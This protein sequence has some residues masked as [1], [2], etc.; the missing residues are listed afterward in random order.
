MSKRSADAAEI[1]MDDEAAAAKK[2]QQMDLVD[3]RS[4][5]LLEIISSFDGREQTACFAE[6]GFPAGAH[7][8]DLTAKQH[9]AS[10]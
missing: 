8:E 9:A 7:F 10:T 2:Q 4:A 6:N 5:E 1:G 3:Q